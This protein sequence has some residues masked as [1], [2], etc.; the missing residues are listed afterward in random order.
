M[1][2]IGWSE[3]AMIALLALIVIGPKDLP[4]VMRTIGQYTRKAR[5]MAR[6][7]QSSLDDMMHEAE[8]DEARKTVEKARTYNPKDEFEREV[9]P[10]GSVRQTAADF[11]REA[12]AHGADTAGSQEGASTSTH[13]AKD[14]AKQ[15]ATETSTENADTKTSQAKAAETPKGGASQAGGSASANSGENGAAA[16]GASGSGNNSKADTTASS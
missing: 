10:D 14:D 5:M 11:D 2:D 13:A 1:L 16:S 6:D 15:S 12:R 3:M 8:L 7:F 4:T 9:D